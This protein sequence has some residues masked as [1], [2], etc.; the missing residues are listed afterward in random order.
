[1]NN[2]NNLSES[3]LKKALKDKKMERKMSKPKM[4]FS[5]RIFIGVTVLTLTIILF[6]M[7]MILK[8][9]DTGALSYLITGVFAQAATCIGFY[10]NKAK[11]ENEIKINK[12]FDKNN[13]IDRM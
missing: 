11:K 12:G 13:H 3:E 2:L 9:E 7:Y 10:Y 4:E 8:T 6:S 5:K 1:M